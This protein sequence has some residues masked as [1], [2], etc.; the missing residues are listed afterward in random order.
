[1]LSNITLRWPINNDLVH[2]KLR[3]ASTDFMIALR[4]YFPLI[5][6]LLPLEI[7]PNDLEMLHL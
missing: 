4:V 2:Q 7:Y 3:K 6:K 5:N 1:M